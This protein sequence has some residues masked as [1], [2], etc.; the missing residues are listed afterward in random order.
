MYYCVANS[1]E[2]VLQ[3]MWLTRKIKP[4]YIRTRE[5]I[6]KCSVITT[7]LLDNIISTYGEE[8][9]KRQN[10]QKKKLDE[11][12]DKVKTKPTNVSKVS[13]EIIFSVL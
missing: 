2:Q 3:E 7:G 6:A 12:V 10:I 1:I 13:D 5:V 8:S 9:Y 11:Y 4:E